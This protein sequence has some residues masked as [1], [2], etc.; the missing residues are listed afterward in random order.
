MKPPIEVHAV[1]Q[2]R[3]SSRRLPGKVLRVVH[4]STLLGH[5]IDR[6]T[7]CA[8]LNGLMIATSDEPSDDPIAAF[9]QAEGVPCHRGDLS[10]VALRMVQAATAGGIR[11]MVR[12]SGDSPMLDPDIVAR[13]VTL[14]RDERPDL[15]TNVQERTFP[16]GQ[17]VEVF[18]RALL[19]QALAQGLD[20]AEREHVTARFYRFPDR[21][22]IRNITHPAAL[23]D[24]QLSV[25][26]EDDLAAFERVA[27]RLGTPFWRHGMQAIVDEVAGSGRA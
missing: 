20:E 17:S 14:Y 16:K 13:A 7:R 19:E 5:L 2:A 10:N 11:H 1:V 21:Y 27:G 6:L 25:D 12:V 9:A 3:M 15:V 4:G 23:G 8:A 26:T 18:P 22:R 24:L